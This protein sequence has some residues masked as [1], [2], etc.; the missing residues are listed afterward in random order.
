MPKIAFHTLGC[1]VNQYE[2][3][4][5]RESFEQAGYQ[6]VSFPNQADVYV[7]NTCTVTRRADQK[8]LQA[9][10]RAVRLNPKAR[11]IVSGCYAQTNP[12]E[13]AGAV[14]V[15]ALVGNEE[16]ENIVDI[17]ERVARGDSLISCGDISQAKKYNGL[18]ISKFQGHSRAFVKIEDGCDLFCSYCKVPYARGPVR[19]RPLEDIEDEVRRLVE[20]G[21]QE[22]VLTGINLGAY[23]RDSHNGLGLAKVMEKLTKI[24]ELP[25]LRLSSL[26]I[27]DLGDD[28]IETMASSGEKVCSYLHLPLQSGDDEILKRMNRGYG[29]DDFLGIVSEIKKR[30]PLV[31]LSTDLLVGFPGENDS[32]FNQ[33]VELIKKAGFIRLHIFPYSS[34]PGTAADRFPDDVP[35]RAKEERVNILRQLGAKLSSNFQ[36]AS[37]GKKKKV[38]I[39]GRRD[40]RNGLLT[41]YS[42]DYLKVWIDGPDELMNRLLEVK[43]TEVKDGLTLG[44][45][46]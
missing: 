36:T 11:V 39:E 31:S 25:R 13:I 6:V 37:L 12:E 9:I 23:G 38:L 26:E 41:G 28:L 10:R 46:V 4:A 20:R 3:Q 43:V 15:D 33:T 18:K 42:D 29:G 22:I 27:T 21:Y 17:V 16:R 40:K 8:S 7:I 34:R 1:K 2:T 45:V 32:Q 14:M 30:I 24:P 5:M 44:K 35:P 19:S